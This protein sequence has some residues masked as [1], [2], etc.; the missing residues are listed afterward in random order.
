[1]DCGHSG[2][3]EDGSN[4][5][6]LLKRM[7]WLGFSRKDSE[8]ELHA[9]S[10]VHTALGSNTCKEAKGRNWAGGEV[11]H[12]CKPNPGHMDAPVSCEAEL[13]AGGCP[14]LGPESWNFG[15]PPELVWG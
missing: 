4:C 13:A 3:R 11:E 14:I 9:E 15:D 12:G 1:M 5:L 10:L 8:I 2:G 6:H 7:S